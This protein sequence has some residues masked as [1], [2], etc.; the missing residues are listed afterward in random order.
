M[1]ARPPMLQV[2][3]TASSLMLVAC[4]ADLRSQD[5]VQP[6]EMTAADVAGAVRGGA[7]LLDVRG[8]TERNRDGA[9]RLP[10][11]WVTFGSDHWRR[12]EPADVAS[13]VHHLSQ[14]AVLPGQR[15]VVL[16]SV[17]VRSAAAADT[18][19]ALGHDA[20]NIREGWL[21]GAAG[22]GLR[23]LEDMQSEEPDS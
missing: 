9:S 12:S 21:G 20:V 10:H 15:L 13:F 17:G 6:P 1:A 2:I 3:L 18:L 16:C 4:G 23:D 8:G 14:T 7:V 19:M 5:R 11:I 22:I